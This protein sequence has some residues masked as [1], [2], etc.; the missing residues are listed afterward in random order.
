MSR[1]GAL[2][3]NLEDVLRHTTT[4]PSTSSHAAQPK[5]AKFKP[6]TSNSASAPPSNAL[7]KQA[8][9]TL[10]S[11]STP[12]FAKS[13]PS[14]SHSRTSFHEP[15]SISSDSPS[16]G[17]K[18]SSSDSHISSDQPSSKRLKS[19][20][21]NLFQ[22]DSCSRVNDK[23]KGKAK[24]VPS[25]STL[26]D[27]DE[28]WNRMKTPEPDPFKMLDR[29]HPR[30]CLP[31]TPASSTRP[32]ELKT[33]YPDLLS[34]ST[35]ELNSILLSNHEYSRQNMEALC[36]YHAGQAAKEDIYTLEAIKTLLDDR[37]CGIKEVIVHLEEGA[38]GVHFTG[39]ATSSVTPTRQQ[40]PPRATSSDT[41]RPA[42]PAPIIASNAQSYEA[43]SYASTSTSV[44]REGSTVSI[45]DNTFTS[46]SERSVSETFAP[47]PDEDD[48]LWA[49]VDDVT[50][51][52]L[53]DPPPVAPAPPT[54]LT[55]PYA[56]EIKWHL[57]RTFDLD[58]FRQNQYEAINATMA[59]RDVFVLMPTGGGKSLCYQLPAVCRGGKTKG[60][61]VV[62][63]PL[64]ALMKDQVNGLKAKGIDAVLWCSETSEEEAQQIRA[65]L[66]SSAKPTLL[67][68]TPER[69]KAS[70]SL[71]N[72]LNYL[73][74]SG[75]LARFVIDEAHCISTWGQD[76]R[77]AYQQLNTLR[78]DYP[79]IPIM[80]L[81][82]TA[83]RKTV[84]DI[85]ARLGL[86][87]VARFEQSFNRTNLYYSVVPK[88]SLDDM[89]NFIKQ[90]HPNE[91][92]VIYRTGRDKCEKLADQLRKKGLKAQHY[93][94]RMDPRDKERVQN[95]WQNGECHIIVATIA[96]G[97]GI[98]KA[99]VRFVIHFDLP[100]NMDGYYQE[101]GR[102]GRDNLPAD[103]ILYYSYRDLQPI[104][105]MIRDNK[106]SNV[107]PESIE[108]QEQA[109]RAVVRYCE[110]NSV[111]RRT[112]VLQH[113]GEK[114]DK[115]DCRGRCNNCEN[116]SFLVTQDFT[117]EAKSVLT[118]VNSLERGQENVTVDHCRNIFK[119]ANV[120]AVREKRHDQH[121]IFGAGK[122]MPKELV[123]LLFNK[124]LYLDAL[125]EQSTQTKANWHQQYLKLGYRANDF[126]TGK[127]VLQL[128]Y[129]PK[130][131]KAGGKAKVTKN[132]RK[133]PAA[134][135]QEQPQ[136]Q[137]R[138]RSLY[139]DDD[140]IEWSPK[141]AA[142]QPAA[143]EV[144]EVISDSE[145]DAPSRPDPETLHRKLVAHRQMILND[146][147]S[148]TKEEVLDDE[149]LEILSVA[150]PQDFLSFKQRMHE[151]VQD[152]FGA[153]SEAKKD[154]DDRCA[155][156]GSGF[157]QLCLGKPVDPKWREKFEY[158]Q[159]SASTSK[160]PLNIRKFKFRTKP[161]E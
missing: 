24:T 105:K 140:E 6:A 131:P 117:K 22:P 119:G 94:A 103:C 82:A 4:N 68:V 57:K 116:E 23:G 107:T 96:F 97:M 38:Y 71:K 75:E 1:A 93:H 42:S 127:A 111:C 58:A 125:K 70:S 122:D 112:Q 50:M 47:N 144:V 84:D 9:T 147:P 151:V 110:N 81:T 13:R 61:T 160:S 108:R 59:G 133:A 121:P 40:T 25:R 113:F 62:V 72:I 106:D 21:E 33:K 148:L 104:L 30:Y 56:A 35:A 18:R 11:F 102:A 77:E 39:L 120:S 37:I 92:G 95:E 76:F 141:K 158:R 114:F 69:L 51:E 89:V 29:D 156:Y 132:S 159:P 12:G 19:E 152:R 3:N 32:A 161:K 31:P 83:D 7:R 46:I 26:E 130:T 139:A 16:P 36:R 136:E 14:G 2:K 20:K 27:D 41:R 124:L 157:L 45:R 99:D 8:S 86:Q 101:T 98:D 80:A 34:K 43:I 54:E 5:S 123:E 115:K 10:P 73:Y 155:K 65:R 137:E 90:C 128:S 74:R 17:V 64:L 91:T 100:K 153:R 109:V 126:L 78:D 138:P 150:P 44:L 154:A 67:Y 135:P 63:S 146:N 129:R 79:N 118:L 142:Y 85:I 60:V 134:P 55:G 52:Y 48:A 15:I 66:Y 88:Q 149:T 145:D 53:D 87:N 143:A 28:P 49:G